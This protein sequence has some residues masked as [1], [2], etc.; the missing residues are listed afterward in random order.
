MMSARSSSTPLPRPWVPDLVVFPRTRTA[1]P[2]GRRIRSRTGA[3]ALLGIGR[4]P[5]ADPFGRG[6]ERVD[7]GGLDHLARDE[8]LDVGAELGQVLAPAGRLVLVEFGGDEGLG[9]GR[10]HRRGRRVPDQ[11][12]MVLA[13]VRFEGVPQDAP[14]RIR[15]GDPEEQRLGDRRHR[16]PDGVDDLGVGVRGIF[17]GPEG[18]F[19]EDGGDDGV[20]AD[21]SEEAV[22]TSKVMRFERWTASA[23]RLSIE[24]RQHRDCLE[25][26]DDVPEHNVGLTAIGGQHHHRAALASGEDVG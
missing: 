3:N 26:A 4:V 15:A 10:V 11:H 8:G 6:I 2:W 23:V 16:G 21:G 7:D 1:G 25:Q 24:R 19:I 5:L 14:S 18:H 13:V 17:R 20:A 12:G 9:D 22:W